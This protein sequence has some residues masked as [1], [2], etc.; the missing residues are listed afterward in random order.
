MSDTK[1]II[2]SIITLIIVF[3][4]LI[5]NSLNMIVFWH[6]TMKKHSTF[7]Y[8]FCLALVDILVLIICA[9]DTLTSFTFSFTF[10]LSSIFLCKIQTFLT[11][12][13]THMSSLILMIVSI[14]RAIIICNNKNQTAANLITFISNLKYRIVCL[15]KKVNNILIFL[16]LFLVMINL[17]SILFMTINKVDSEKVNDFDLNNYKFY[18]NIKVFE[19]S[20]LTFKSEF[21]D[22]KNKSE[23]LSICYPLKNEKYYIFLLNIWIWIDALTYSLIPF[24]VMTMSSIIIIVEIRTKSNGF[25]KRY[26][27]EKNE[28]ERSTMNQKICEKS[29][30]RNRKLSIMLLVNNLIFILCSLPIRFNMIYYNNQ[31]NLK[32]ETSSSS[33]QS[34]FHPFS[35]LNNSFNFILYFIFSKQYRTLVLK[36]FFGQNNSDVVDIKTRPCSKSKSHQ[37]VAKSY[38]KSTINLNN[39]LINS[40]SVC[41]FSISKLTSNRNNQKEPNGINNKNSRNLTVLYSDEA[42][43]QKKRLTIII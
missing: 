33:F 6:K 7:R 25:I 5:G 4:G 9:T 17:H 11:Y 24:L 40:T 30:R 32:D 22:N 12:F 27:K 26:G 18:N 42:S 41:E 23:Y 31:N 1:Q 13:L 10:R 43:K 8:L 15:F 34:F 36:L 37:T 35:Y 21:E 14:D 29:K 28:R 2:L 39:E 20:N 19:N 3:F 16:V 38:Q